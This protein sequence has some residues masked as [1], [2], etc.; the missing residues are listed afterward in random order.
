MKNE[1]IK[2]FDSMK[3]WIVEA[4]TDSPGDEFHWSVLKKIEALPQARTVYRPVISSLGWKLIVGFIASIFAWCILMVPAR[5]ETSTLFDKIP[6]LK[7]P[8]PSFK[9]VDLSF[10]IPDFGPQFLLGIAVFFIMSFLLII[11]T[12]QNKQ[13]KV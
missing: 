7:T 5:P 8:I 10:S 9:L 4:G 2:P 11:G 6:K 1:K 12:L 13:A 3:K